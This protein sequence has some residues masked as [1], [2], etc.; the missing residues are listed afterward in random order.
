MDLIKLQIRKRNTTSISSEV[1]IDVDSIVSPIRFNSTTSRSYFT[2]VTK[3]PTGLPGDTVKYE[4][5]DTLSSIQGMS[6]RLV[7]L[8]IT[9]KNGKAV[10]ETMVFD[11]NKVAEGFYLVPDGSGDCGFLYCEYGNPSPVDYRTSDVMDDIVAQTS[12]SSHLTGNDLPLTIVSESGAFLSIN[13]STAIKINKG[14]VDY[15]IPILNYP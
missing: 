5:T 13:D 6:A 1:A 2:I 9:A 4:V 3:T 10:S 14:G 15:Y 11:V 12:I 8:A 7:M